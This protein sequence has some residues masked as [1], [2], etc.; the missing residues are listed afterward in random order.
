MVIT[1]LLILY[2]IIVAIVV[3]VSPYFLFTPVNIWVKVTFMGYKKVKISPMRLYSGD[4]TIT[5]TKDGKYALYSPIHPSID[6]YDLNPDGTANH[7]GLGFAH[8]TWEYVKKPKY[9]DQVID[10][11]TF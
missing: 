4:V 1:T 2:T 7:S 6:G 10:V 8:A 9:L 3:C 11:K 5:V